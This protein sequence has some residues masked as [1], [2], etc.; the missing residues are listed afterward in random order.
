MPAHEHGRHQRQQGDVTRQRPVE[1]GALAVGEEAQCQETQHDHRARERQVA[2]A[3][4]HIADTTPGRD[5]HRYQQQ[6]R[7]QQQLHA[8]EAKPFAAELPGMAVHQLEAQARIRVVQV[9]EQQRQPGQRAHR[10][11]RPGPATA[12]RGA[13]FAQGQQGEQPDR[14]HRD[15]AVMG[16]PAD[17]QTQRQFA[18]GEGIDA[19]Q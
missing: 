9:P 4:T 15:E 13:P 7:G 1:A 5:D 17:H 2:H 16:Q 18:S 12:Q 19:A 3:R 6:R 14:D 8:S 10:D 11:R